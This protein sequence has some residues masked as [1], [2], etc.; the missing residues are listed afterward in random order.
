MGGGGGGDWAQRPVLHLNKPLMTD[1]R[2][3]KI[4]WKYW[5]RDFFVGSGISIYFLAKH[6][7]LVSTGRFFSL[8]FFVS[9]S[10]NVKDLSFQAALYSY[11]WSNLTF[12]TFHGAFV[13]PDQILTCLPYLQLILSESHP[14]RLGYDPV[15]AA[16][17]DIKILCQFCPNVFKLIIWMS[18][19]AFYNLLHFLKLDPSV[20]IASGGQIDNA[21]R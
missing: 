6:I 9:T 4:V 20:I 11:C 8:G 21:N 15:S 16:L 5:I 13:N 14:R 18:K 7:I 19:R 3:M 2:S 1:S 17:C 10:E 12:L